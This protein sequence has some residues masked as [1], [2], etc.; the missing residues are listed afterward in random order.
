M[1]LSMSMVESRLI[2]YEV[3]SNIDD[4]SRTIR[5]MRLISEQQV[6]FSREYIYIGQAADFLDDPRYAS[7]FILASGRN[8]IVCQGCDYETLL[9]DVLGA[10]DFYNEAEERLLVAASRHA[11]L[12]DMMP[13][14][15]E[16]LPDPFVVFGIDGSVLASVNAEQIPSQRMRRN[17]IERQNLSADGIGG[18]FVDEAGVVHHD[19]TAVPLSMR[20]D[21]GYAAVSMYIYQ[22][23][24][25]IG[26]AMHFPSSKKADVLAQAIDSVIA[27]HLAQSE[28]FTNAYSPHQSLRLALAELMGGGRVSEEATE[29]LAVAVGGNAGLVVISVASLVIQNRTQRLLLANE[30]EESRVACVACELEEA[31]AFL[32]TVENAEALVEQIALRF[33]SK[34][35][36]LGV[37]MPVAGFG[38]L[39]SAYR[40]AVFA[41][42]SSPSAGIRHC[43]HLALPFLIGVLQKESVA[44]DLLHPALGILE[45]Y[46]TENGTDL[47]ETLRAYVETGCSQ[48]ET[49]QKLYVHLNTLKY[50]LRRIGELTG[51]DFRDRENMFY[52]ELSLRLDP[53]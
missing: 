43:R 35:L 13:T 36:A 49:A 46:D 30:V 29:R 40:Q 3:E 37:S 9:N 6:E 12:K 41:R 8:N 26:F 38:R 11:Q 7:A 21:E 22:E 32:A 4:D 52:I 2:G 44:R 53:R 33:N 5:G 39:Q 42:D 51:I 23:S 15:E 10:F 34:S 25:P 27:K 45:S 50:R 17:V 48:S 18:Y 19:L 24:E 14:V 28:E 20:D 1:K 16:M 31:V 47:L